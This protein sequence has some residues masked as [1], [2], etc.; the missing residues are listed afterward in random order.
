MP[1]VKLCAAS[2]ENTA[3]GKGRKQLLTEMSY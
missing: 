2:D 1:K 3:R